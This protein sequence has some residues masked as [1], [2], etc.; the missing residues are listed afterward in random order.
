MTDLDNCGACAARCNVPGGSS[1]CLSG[2]CA[3]NACVSPNANCDGL[4]A[5]GCE[6]DTSS[7][8]QHCGGC[9][10][11]CKVP[12]AIPSCVMSSCRIGGCNGTFRDCNGNASDGCEADIANDPADCGACGNKCILPNA[13]AGCV[14]KT[15]T[16]G[17][18]NPGFGDCDGVAANGCETGTNGGDPANC[19]GCKRACSTAQTAQL[20]CGGGGICTSSCT[21]GFA[22]CTLPT[23]AQGPDDGCET[24]TGGDTANCGG[25]GRACLPINTS[26]G[27]LSCQSGLC[28][29]TCTSGFA[30]C[31][32]P[33]APATDDG[34]E[35]P[36]PGCCGSDC[37]YTHSN[38]VGQAF[39]DCAPLDTYS[40]TEATNAANA[41]AAL[42]SGGTVSG[43]QT[44]TDGTGGSLTAVCYQDPSIC[45]CWVYGDSGTAGLLGHVLQGTTT[46]GVLTSAG[47]LWH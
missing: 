33:A 22:N 39:Y 27:L 15:C 35:C 17:I 20:M 44:F 28:K 4:A 32:T 3:I 41:L 25:C 38:G 8:P 40:S 19:G 36:T 24:N 14:N 37:E 23:V 2:I 18:C 46:C 34:C 10:L 30:N 21:S 11:S 42:G 26:T 43:T 13:V 9:N 5:N 29:S 45:D 12:N 31:R 16:V 47:Q 1:I 7:D 6:T